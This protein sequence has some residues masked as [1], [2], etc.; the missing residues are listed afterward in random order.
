MSTTATLFLRLNALRHG[1]EATRVDW[2]LFSVAGDKIN[3]GVDTAIDQIETDFIARD[4]RVVVIVPGEDCLFS[5]LTVPAAQKR[6]LKQT[7]PYLVEEVVAEPVE[8]MHFASGMER[9]GTYPVMA[10]SH[11][12]MRDWLALLQQH[13]ITPDHMVS[14]TYAASLSATATQVLFDGAC[15]ILSGNAGALKTE[16]GN[17][18]LFLENHISECKTEGTPVTAIK[19]IVSEAQLAEVRTNAEMANT[20]A[21]LESRGI[22][23]TLEKIDNAF[24]YLCRHLNRRYNTGRRKRMADLIQQPY[25]VHALKQRQRSWRPIILAVFLCAGLKVA[26]DAAT[27]LYL[28]RRV[29]QQDKQVAALYRSLFPQDEKIVNVRVQVETHLRKAVKARPKSGFLTLLGL[30]SRQLSVMDRAADM[31]VQQLRYDSQQNTLWV[32]IH[33]KHVQQLDQLKLGLGNQDL[34]VTILSASSEREWVRGRLRITD[35]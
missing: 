21:F 9:E 13:G 14:D 7:L 30:F 22:V 18:A 3:G 23:C 33:V 34:A 19:I 26:V 4:L 1:D 25:R 10:A 2:G 16:T 32:D 17:I 6:Y 15:A 31:Q 29:A 11:A 24:D 20:T 27:G 5:R 12:R 35:T 8:A 28:E